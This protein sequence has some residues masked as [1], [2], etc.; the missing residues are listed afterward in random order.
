MPTCTGKSFNAEKGYK[1][2]AADGG[3][4]DVFVQHSVINNLGA[5]LALTCVRELSPSSVLFI[6]RSVGDSGLLLQ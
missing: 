3:G 5:S 4:A 6:T 2:I 1:M